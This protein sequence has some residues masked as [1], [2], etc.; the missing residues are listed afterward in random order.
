MFFREIEKNLRI[1]LTVPQFA[2][3]L[4]ALTDQNREYLKVRLPWLD[5]VQEIGDT[6]RF[7]REQLLKFAKEE[8]L[9]LSILSNN[10][11]VGVVGYNQLDLVNGV[12]I[13][14]YWLSEEHTGKGVMTKAVKEVIHM[15]FGSWPLQKVEIHCAVDNNSSRAIPERLG[16]REE[17]TIRRTAKVSET[18]HDHVIYGLLE[19]EYQDSPIFNADGE[20]R[21]AGDAAGMQA[22]LEGMGN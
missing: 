8:A 2:G 19:E 10:K 14:G 3:Q 15:G 22:G 6:K 18:H 9:H 12:G 1:A 21:L 11:I 4:F 20:G 5:S 17:G 16:F 13:I 7:I